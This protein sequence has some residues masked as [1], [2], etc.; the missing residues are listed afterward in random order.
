MKIVYLSGSAIPSR[1]ANSIQVMRMCEAFAVNGH[2]TTLIAKQYET[3]QACAVYKYYGVREKFEL[4]LLS[5]RKIKGLNV[6]LLPK[7][8]RILKRYD[9]AEVL[10]YARDIYGASLAVQMGFRVIYE[11]HAAPYNRVISHLEASLLKNPR[12]I[13]LVVISKALETLYTSKFDIKEKVVV[14]HDA[15]LVPNLSSSA[16]LAWPVCR[17]TLQ[18]GYMGH[19]YPGRG[20]EIILE[21]A[22]RL[23]EYDFHIVGGEESDIVFWKSRS[24]AN[25][26]FHGFLEPAAIHN[27]HAK[28]NVLLMPYQREI[29]NPHSHL[30]TVPWMS[31]MK[32]FEYMASHRAIVASDLPAIREVLDEHMAVLVQPDDLEQWINGIRRCEDPPYRQSL[33]DNAYNAF[34]QHHTW[35]KRARTVLNGV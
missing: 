22:K 9:P 6:L 12:L 8:Y 31:P 23:P 14:C 28:C 16:D 30:N 5:C 32:L 13:R 25:V 2:A 29:I 7:L 27:A 11:A 1:G 18:I 3:N 26:Y 35:E 20:V 15:A 24:S 19:L 4:V 17:G 34:V 33:A 21:C 10:I